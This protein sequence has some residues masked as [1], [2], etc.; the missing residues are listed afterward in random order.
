MTKLINDFLDNLMNGKFICI[1]L[2]DT[3]T[4]EEKNIAQKINYIVNM[5]NEL[6]NYTLSLSKGDISVTPPGR[7][8]FLAAGVKT[9]HAQLNHITW[10]AQQVSH[11]DFN[12]VVDFMGEFSSAFNQMTQMLKKRE[13]TN[14]DRLN[15]LKRIFDNLNMIIAVLDIDDKSILFLNEAAINY[16]KNISDNTLLSMIENNLPEMNNTSFFFEKKAQKWFQIDNSIILWE[17]E[18]K[19]LL[20]SLLDITEVKQTEELLRLAVE[21]KAGIEKKRLE[22]ELQL[23]SIIVNNSPQCMFYVDNNGDYEFFNSATINIT[24]YSYEELKKGGIYMLY[25][26]PARSHLKNDIIPKVLK[27]GKYEYE[28]PIKRK[29]GEVLTIL[30]TAFTINSDKKH[31][32]VIA[33]DITLRKQLEEELL[34]AKILAENSSKAKSEFLSRMSHEMRTPMNAILGMTNIAKNTLENNKREYCLDK[35]DYA[36]QHLSNVIDGILDMSKIEEGKIELINNDFDIHQMIDKIINT[37]TFRIEEKKLKLHPYIDHSLSIINC[38]ELRLSQI[39]I[40]LLSNAIK[41]TFENGT[42]HLNILKEKEDN[43]FITL[44]FEVIDTGIGISKEQQ[45]KLFASFEQIQG[46]TDREYEGV[47]LSLA[48]SKKIIDLMSGN[49]WVESKLGQGSTFVFTIPVKKNIINIDKEDVS[50]NIDFSDHTILLVDD[51]EVNREI[52]AAFLE[53]VNIRIDHAV[54]GIEAV[55]M[56]KNNPEKYSLIFMDIHMPKMDGFDATKNIRKIPHHY[57]KKIPIIALT[58]NTFREDIE[59]C[60]AAGMNEHIGKPV[61]PDELLKKLKFFIPKIKERKC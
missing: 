41:F 45:E 52:V 34:E 16:Q 39:I 42:I 3:M 44:R 55:D 12:Q 19:S 22:K 26:E 11:G 53:E 35:I 6:Q 47:G 7:K 60:F 57:A 54:N 50:T 2:N 28:L 25:D 29:N 43:E 48:F 20:C 10:Q 24:G 14:Q 36:A 32:A 27:D 9:L 37:L 61:D 51:V 21:Q 49:I 46:G 31:I 59:K 4:E 13:Q 8:N 58:A 17:E 33:T 38:D 30:F 5:F 18:K 56:F 40:N 1:S 15:A 23:M